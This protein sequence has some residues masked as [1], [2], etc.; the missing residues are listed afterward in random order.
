MDIVL[1]P[2]QQECVDIINHM[3]KGSGLVHMAT[4]LGKTVV[5]THL[6][7]KGRVL[8]LSHRDELVHQPAQYYS[9]SIGIEAGNKHATGKEQVI[10]A[11]VL[12]MVNRLTD[13][14]QD[15]FDMIITDEAHH[16][17]APSYQ[18]IYNYF[19]PRLHIGFTA[20]PN[21][22]DCVRLD[23]VYDRIIFQ[24]DLKW[25]M[26][27]NYL[28]DIDCIRAG[29]H[30]DLSHVDITDGDFKS[31]Q[32]ESVM[33]HEDVNRDIAE[34]YSKYHIGQT[35]IFAT[36]IKQAELLQKMIPHSQV[37]TS[38]TSL[39]TRRELL[40]S[41]DKGS[42]PCL[43]NCNILAE[44]VNLPSIRTVIIARP[45]KNINLYMQM[46]GRGMR[47]IDGVKETLRL[48]DCVDMQEESDFCSAPSLLGID[49][50]KVPKAK[51]KMIRGSLK[52]I[53]QNVELQFNSPAMLLKN[54]SMAEEYAK[55]HRLNLLGLNITML[56]NGD[57]LI[58]IPKSKIGVNGKCRIFIKAMDSLGMT[59]LVVK[60]YFPVMQ[61]GERVDWKVESI[62]T[63]PVHLQEA[64]CTAKSFCERYY[65]KEK[66]IW[67]LQE[68]SKYRD[69]PASDNQKEAI[70]TALK[71]I[72]RREDFEKE[73]DFENL[74]RGLATDILNFLY[75][76]DKML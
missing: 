51:R 27:N 23:S 31:A 68:A 30:F 59:K 40:E 61:N 1:R 57:M 66:H 20:T 71:N 50:H 13:Y 76:N 60:R 54:V 14:A 33:N 10:S 43:I 48:I 15:A 32:L 46:V 12:S 41:F 49:I 38:D 8:I 5:F 53:E 72:K 4:G 42:F 28:C 36:S 17:V 74:T 39:K 75:N 3:E 6:N 70:R 2:Y 52:E 47:R 55:E 34:V 63:K 56:Y 9:F 73:I 26:D 45:T 24:R 62:E 44:G 58:N 7:R 16:S 37:V 29:C 69:A 22:G 19:K 25:G 18:R 21:R 65:P 64:I 11:S 35:L 67:D